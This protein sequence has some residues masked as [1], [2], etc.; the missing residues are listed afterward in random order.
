MSFVREFF[1]DLRTPLYR[2]A[3]YLMANTL[4]NNLFGFVFWMIVAWFYPASDFGLATALI[5]AAMLIASLSTLGLDIG[6]IRY[7]PDSEEKEKSMVNT[8]F[9]ITGGLAIII[10]V[11]FLLGLGFWSPALAFL[12]GNSFFAI[13]FVFFAAFFA[14]SLVM[15]NV[16]IAKRTVKYMFLKNIVYGL[17]RIGL[18]VAFAI[19]FGAFGIF[20]S[21]GVGAFVA[22]LVGWMFFMRRIIP[23]YWPRPGVSRTVVRDILP[24]SFG[25]YAAGILATLPG[26]VLPLM[27]LNLGTAEVTAYFYVA[28]M[29]AGIL[30]V[31]P[32]AVSTS[33]F[34][35]GSH[36]QESLLRD[37]RKSL[38]LIFPL[39]S[40]G[41]L[42]VFF[43]GRY[44]LLLFGSEFSDNAFDLLMI[45]A[46]SGFFVSL[47][48]VYFSIKRVEE[49]VMP[50]I[51]ICAITTA[52]T[53]GI[54]YSLFSSMGLL[55][56]GIGWTVS[57]GL[58][59]LG[60]GLTYVKKL[61]QRG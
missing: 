15:N 56:V 9:S 5:A 25:N 30:F 33:L 2:N 32:R 48:G 60:I 14:L 27:I 47:N 34:A 10:A 46:L 21:W 59:S 49:K 38:K 42:V 18:P 57:Q 35:E 45:L 19:A 6:L 43:F 52:G 1:R 61:L 29:I 13:A 41:I 54:S 7:L 8:I 12:V 26:F 50:I 44:L 22:L 31:V 51:L 11:I 24:F 53:L 28:W 23:N 39:M 58:A 55:S 16:F 40:V 37:V 4:A 17:T 36:F 20:A 3:L